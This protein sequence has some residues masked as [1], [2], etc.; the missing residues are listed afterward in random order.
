MKRVLF[1]IAICLSFMVGTVN[2]SFPV[3]GEK[4]TEATE[5]ITS[6]EAAAVQ[7]VIAAQDVIISENT[8]SAEEDESTKL[9]EDDWITLALLVF[10]GGFAAHRWYKKKP[11]GWNILFILT[12]GGCG[13]WAIVDLVNILTGKF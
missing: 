2:A 1:T 7:E 9:K 13:I 8:E 6:N 11:V 5:K 12:G 4:N 10:L 3:K